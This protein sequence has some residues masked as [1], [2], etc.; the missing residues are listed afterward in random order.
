VIEETSRRAQDSNVSIQW[1]AGVALAMAGAWFTIGWMAVIAAE[2]ELVPLPVRFPTPH[3]TGNVFDVPSGPDFEKYTGE[4][5]KLPLVPKGVVNV[6]LKKPVKVSTNL[7][8]G[9][10]PEQIT[11]GEKETS[12]DN[13][14]IMQRGLQWV[15]VDLQERYELQAVVI[16][17]GFG[18]LLPYSKQVIV[19]V[20]DDGEFTKNVRTLFNNDRKNEAGL[21]IGKDLRYPDTCNGR[22]IRGDGRPARYVRWYS[23]GSD[24]TA[25]NS[26]IEMEVWAL[27]KSNPAPAAK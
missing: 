4:V 8:D 23:N 16:W 11:D 14:M 12:D 26:R 3:M 22:V 7:L 10:R 24:E 5:P 1:K 17:H 15:Q 21:G 9:C 27:P 20:A 25:F 2:P 18:F 19:Q 6:A 13:R